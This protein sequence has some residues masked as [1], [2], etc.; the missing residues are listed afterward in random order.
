M[1]GR[2]R[3][4]VPA[5]LAALLL[6]ATGCVV[7]TTGGGSASPEVPQSASPAAVAPADPSTKPSSPSKKSASGSSVKFENFEVTVDG[8]QRVSAG[9]YAVRAKVCALSLPENPNGNRTRI[10]RDP[11]SVVS[12]KGSV[13]AGSGD[14]EA[15]SDFPVETLR[16]AGT[17]AS[18]WL[19]FGVRGSV[20]SVV[21]KNGVGDEAVW[22]TDDLSKRPVS[23]ASRSKAAAE[24]TIGE[25]T[26]LVGEDIEPGRYKARARAGMACYWARLR[27]DS[28]DVGSIIA[29]GYSNGAASVTIRSSDGAFET[30][31]CTGWTLR[32]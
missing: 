32:S 9:T 12:A 8:A 19:P 23:S 2:P 7:V 13:D 22:D 15:G 21:Y 25:G 31:G 11:W 6:M 18:G 14:S 27:N 30:S 20:K 28:G 16:R 10:S 17:C 24:S 5:G 3:A 1:L 26:Y 4:A 29:N